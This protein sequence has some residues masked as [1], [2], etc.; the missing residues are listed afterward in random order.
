MSDEA[1]A[2]PAAA[3]QSPAP[4]AQVQTPSPIESNG[5]RVDAKPE[6]KAEPKA[7]A[8]DKPSSSISEA[9]KKAEAKVKSDTEAKAKEPEKDAKPEPKADATPAPKADE[10][11]RGADGKFVS[12]EPKQEAQAD[13]KDTP[14]RETPKRFSEDGKRDWEKAPDS[15]KAETHRAIRELESGIKEYKDRY[16]PLKPYDEIARQ[17]NTTVKDA[18]DRYTSLEK[19]LTSGDPNDKWAALQKVFDYAGINVREFAA[20]ITV[21]GQI[22]SPFTRSIRCS[23][24]APVLRNSNTN[25]QVT[26]P[27]KSKS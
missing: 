26:G 4:E 14:W 5:P 13:T 3:E 2:A 16:E 22:R 15:V 20:Q 10:S 6:P 27:K 7:E 8:K 11:N 17:N 12:K 19:Q 24:F 25:F 23:S 21:S 18:L 9:L 1:G